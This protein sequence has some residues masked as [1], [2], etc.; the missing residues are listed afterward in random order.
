MCCRPFVWLFA[1]L[2]LGAC[3]TPPESRTSAHPPIVFIHG[4]FGNAAGW[5]PTMWRF[6]SNGW[7]RDRLFAVDVPNPRA[8]ADDGV[9]MAGRSSS[10]EHATHLAAEVERVLT[11]TGASKAIIIAHSRGGL[12]ARDFVRNGGASKVSHVIMGATPNR[13]L[14]IGNEFARNSEHNGAGRYMTALNSPQGPDGL[15]VTPGVAFMTLRSDSQDKFAMPDGR[16]LGQPK[17]KTNLT[18]EA[19]A[20]KGAENVVIPG[21]DH[22]EA[23]YGPQAFEHVY[24]FITGSAPRRKEIVPEASVVLDGKI[25]GWIGD[26][27]TNLPIAGASVEIHEVSAATGER[28]GAGPVHAR[29]V[30]ADGSWGPFT[31]KPDAR[32]EF[33]VAAPGYATTHFYRSPFPRSSRYVHLRPVIMSDADRKAASVVVMHRPRGFLGVGRD[34]M[35][36]DGKPPPGVTPGVPGDT[37]STLRLADESPRSVAAELNGERIVVR[38]WPTKDNRL[39]RAE[40]HY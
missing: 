14:W 40:F 23:T 25:T 38:T 2:L 30:G 24:R 8:R 21:A 31:G 35:S 22:N 17:L 32:Y 33:V 13:G 29:T 1:A 3:A 11:L 34:A 6:E 4:A 39:V 12:A 10:A 16:W 28:L 15:E 20:L 27:P 9:P 5:I 19:P 18:A 36:L 7:P 37:S 26:T